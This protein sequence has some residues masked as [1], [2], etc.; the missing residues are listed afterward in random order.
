MPP[1]ANKICENSRSFA[2]QGKMLPM[3]NK[4]CENNKKGAEN[5]QQPE[6]D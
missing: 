3:V 1:M 5:Y 6:K 4:I 2:T